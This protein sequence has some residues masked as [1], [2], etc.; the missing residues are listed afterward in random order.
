[1]LLSFHYEIVKCMCLWPDTGFV[2]TVYYIK[3]LTGFLVI[4]LLWLNES[5]TLCSFAFVFLYFFIPLYFCVSVHLCPFFYAFIFLLIYLHHPAP[6]FSMYPV[7]LFFLQ[8]QDTAL[9]F[10]NT[11]SINILLIYYSICKLLC[12]LNF[13]HENRPFSVMIFLI[14]KYFICSLFYIGNPFISSVPLL[15]VYHHSQ[16]SIIFLQTLDIFPVLSYNKNNNQTIIYQFNSY[17]KE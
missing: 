8:Y 2:L 5:V 3:L 14:F 4:F 11:A 15:S 7:H 16:Y 17:G 12:N 9:L 10:D 1:M 6:H 13:H